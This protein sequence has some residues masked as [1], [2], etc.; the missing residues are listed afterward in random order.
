MTSSSRYPASEQFY[1]SR[2]ERDVAD[3]LDDRG[4]DY[5][6]ET[7][8]IRYVST[9]TY[10]PDFIL[11][12]GIYIEVKGWFKPSDRSKHLKIKDQHPNLDVRFVFDRASQKLS[13][14][15][16]TSYAQWCNRYGFKWAEKII[17][18]GWLNEPNNKQQQH[19]RKA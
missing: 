1:R 18:Q 9:R 10:I 16:N 5:E 4:V 19:I 15:S 2:L 3:S 8:R 12:N 7:C 6:Y 14:Q 11:A 13:R 17:P